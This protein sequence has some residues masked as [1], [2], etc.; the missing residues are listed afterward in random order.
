[1]VNNRN[2]LTY[3]ANILTLSIALVLFAVMNDPVWEFRIMAFT[4]AGV[5][6]CTSLFYMCNIR[7]VKLQ[8]MAEEFDT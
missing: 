8:K 4:G 2:A 3:G 6:I 7:E 1:M 5:G